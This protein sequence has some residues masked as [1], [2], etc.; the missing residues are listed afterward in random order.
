MSGLFGGGSNAAQTSQAVGIRVQSSIYGSVLPIVYGTNRVAG[1]LIWYGN[2][3]AS[4]S[5]SGGGKSGG[6]GGKGSGGYT[7]SAAVAIALCEGPIQG[8]GTV[9]YSSNYINT[10]NSEGQQPIAQIGFG[11]F[12]GNYT[13]APWSYLVSQFP[14]VAYN[15]RGVAYVANSDISLG[16]SPDLPN[17]SFEVYGLLQTSAQQQDVNPAAIIPDMLTNVNYGC[18]WNPSWID[19]T[20]LFEYGQYCAVMGF[21]FSPVYNSQTQAQQNLQ[22]LMDASNSTCWWSDGVLKIYPFADQTV[23]GNGVTFTPNVTPIYS[24]SDDDFIF[25]DGEDPVKVARAAP[26]DAYNIVDIQFVNRANGYASQVAEAKDIYAVSLYGNRYDTVRDYEFITNQ[27]TAQTVAQLW[28]QRNLYIR[29]TY[30]F[31]LGWAFCALEPMDIVDLND[32][33]MGLSNWPVRITGVEENDNGELTFTAE[34]FPVGFATAPTYA[35]QPPLSEQP[36]WNVAAPNANQ[37]VFYE[38]PGP[39][40]NNQ[41]VLWLGI[42]GTGNWGGAEVWV[43]LDGETYLNV[44]TFNGV[45]RVGTITSVLNINGDPDTIDILGVNLTNSAGDLASG[46]RADADTYNTLCLVGEELISYETAALTAVS[47]YNLTYLRRGAYNTAES[48]WPIGTQFMRCDQSVFSYPFDSSL[49][50]NPVYVK[51]VPFNQY[52][53][54]SP[55][56]ADVPVYTYNIQGS[57][58]NAALPNVTGVYTNFV[59]GITQLFWSPVIDYRNFDYEIRVG[60]TWGTGIFLARTTAVSFTTAGNGNYWVAAHFRNPNGFDVYSDSPTNVLVSGS[61]LVLNNVTTWDE[62]ATGWSGTLGGGAAVASSELT[63]AGASNIL[64]ASNV[65]TISNILE[66]GGVSTLGMYTIPTAHNINVGYP[67]NCSVRLN[68]TGYGLNITDNILSVLNI[69]SATDLLDAAANQYVTITPQIAIAPSS[70]I[71]GSWQNYQP[72]VYVGQYFKAQLILTSSDPGVT[73]I[74]TAFTFAVDVNLM[75]LNFTN[76]AI[77]SG[78]TT[79]PYGV[80]YNA[81]PNGAATPNVQI[82][83]LNASQGDT[84]VISG[85]TLSQVTI[86]VLNGGVGVARTVDIAVTGY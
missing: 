7:Y 57:A 32:P 20:H 10:V 80:T 5:S 61:M 2:F 39:L 8:I 33:L 6:G 78:G 49:I 62:V 70:G 84:V 35:V 42:A 48:D 41:L 68:F 9:W 82:S 50:G 85:K 54:G 55:S 45:T 52:G 24:L 86:Q 72:G 76:E 29:N 37:V 75:V 65:L 69:L 4:K 3:Q 34:D 46:T 30:T 67:S 66:Y 83:V 14:A 13:Q 25:K 40:T 79:I 64:T 17:Y 21:Q 53:G 11:L 36:N 43:S 56:I 59:S 27:T 74:V 23:T 73:P 81:G 16:T 44:G 19:A 38:P 26:A 31:T 60:A 77:A 22:D 63:L 28:L 15:Y 18:S 47:Q 12:P 58:V 1:N 71:F 51:L